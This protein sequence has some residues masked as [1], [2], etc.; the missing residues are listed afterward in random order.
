MH[1][2]T[3]YLGLRRMYYV[4]YIRSLHLTYFSL[5]DNI[6]P[7]NSNITLLVSTYLQTTITNIENTWWQSPYRLVKREKMKIP[8]F[9][10]WSFEKNILLPVGHRSKAR[11]AGIIH[12]VGRRTLAA[13][14]LEELVF[15]LCCCVSFWFWWEIGFG[16]PYLHPR[17]LDKIYWF[18]RR[19]SQNILPKTQYQQ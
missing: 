1:L 8:I 14:G 17:V 16:F 6:L 9:L 7:M 10:F 4:L 15:Q 12:S 19:L 18:L 5:T 3:S 2:A 13:R 11:G